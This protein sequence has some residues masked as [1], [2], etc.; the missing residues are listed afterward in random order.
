[1]YVQLNRNGFSAGQGANAYTVPPP[2]PAY[3]FPFEA[4]FVVDADATGGNLTIQSTVAVASDTIV[5][6]FAAPP[7]SPGI[8]FAKDKSKFIGLFT[9]L[10]ATVP[11]T[12]NDILAMWVSRFGTYGVDLIGKK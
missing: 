10:S 1:A 12:D 11:P 5:Q 3:L 6:I 2:E 9:V 4:N 7:L 8:T